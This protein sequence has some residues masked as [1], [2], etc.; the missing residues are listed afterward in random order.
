M[1]FFEF[2]VRV[3]KPSRR[4]SLRSLLVATAVIAVILAIYVPRATYDVATLLKLSHPVA[5]PR[6]ESYDE[7]EALSL[8]VELIQS[9]EVIQGSLQATA[10]DDVSADEIQRRL[11]AGVV[12]HSE[13]VHITLRCREF[14]DDKDAWTKLLDRMVKNA[15]ATFDDGVTEVT[16]LKGP[17]VR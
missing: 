1:D 15:T 13:L 17:T 10:I 7:H 2:T 12:G 8:F 9:D 14:R 3:P 5:V 11:S 4:F 16:I 6:S